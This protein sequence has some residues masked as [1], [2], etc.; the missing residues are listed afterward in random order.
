MKFILLFLLLASL[1]LFPPARAFAV[2][3]N[4]EGFVE[5]YHA[6]RIHE[7]WD[8]T[9]SR[10]RLRLGLWM[11]ADRLSAFGSINLGMDYV[12]MTHED[13]VLRSGGIQYKGAFGELRELFM[14]YQHEAFDVRIGRQIVVWGKADGLAITDIVSPRDYT[15]FLATE[16]EDTR[17][18]VEAVR[19]RVLHEI[20][21]FELVWLP[22]FQ[23]NILPIEGS[24]WDIPI[25]VPE[26]MTLFVKET[27][28][29]DPGIDSS[30]IG[31]K[32]SFYTS[33]ADFSFSGFYTW[34]D[35]ATVHREVNDPDAPTELALS[36]KHH[37]LG[38]A[39]FDLSAPV[40]DFVFRFE[41]AFYFNKRFEGQQMADTTTYTRPWLV[42]MGGV[43]WTPPGDW[44]ITT[45]FQHSAV[46]DYDSEV[47]TEEHD[48]LATLKISKLLLRQTLELSAM[49]YMG[50]NEPN[51][52]LRAYIDYAVSDAFHVRAGGDAFLGTKSSF[53]QYD[54]NDDVFVK[55][56]VSF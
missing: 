45:Q 3:W 1:L 41:S 11:T 53:G 33:A 9:T 7:P 15:D 44:T 40:S 14:E 47:G 5:T 27:R 49:G 34:D 17:I 24:P 39:G 16:Y 25:A 55:A 56:K 4:P 26:G 35:T 32:L 20:V 37:R 31:G 19:F 12:N 52:F 10:T 48:L 50:I 28:R 21:D 46:F 18:P 23:A 38:F 30:E 2:E 36:P 29:P 54:N 22:I 8:F 51:G 43:D 6:L 13:I 42:W